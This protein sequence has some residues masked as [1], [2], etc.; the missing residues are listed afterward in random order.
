MGAGHIVNK[1]TREPT[2]ERTID[3]Y[4]KAIAYLNGVVGEQVLAETV[5]KEFV[6][7]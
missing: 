1:K 4:C 2:A 7:S 6:Q 5:S 3:Y